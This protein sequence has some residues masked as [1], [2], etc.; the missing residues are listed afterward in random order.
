MAATQT[1]GGRRARAFA[2][3]AENIE[4]AARRIEADLEV[5][6]LKFSGV[7]YRDMS[8][9]GVVFIDACGDHIW[10]ELPLEGKRLQGK[11]L[12]DY[13]RLCELLRVL[14]AQRPSQ[15]LAEFNEARERVVEAIEQTRRT[16]FSSTAEAH[17]ET[18][19][20]FRQQCEF[21]AGLHS[22]RES[23]VLVPRRYP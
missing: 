5:L 7:E 22:D 15:E 1:D 14:L 13:K 17:S 18:V 6:F 3:V 8:S 20:L 9:P 19:A 11:I 23:V 10:R 12:S 16:W 2:T 21:V 4:T